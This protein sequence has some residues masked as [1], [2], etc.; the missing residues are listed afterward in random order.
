MKKREYLVLMALFVGTTLLP[1]NAYAAG[2]EAKKSTATVQVNQTPR[3]FE[4]YTV[5]NYSYFNLRDVAFI[6][7]NTEKEFS[8]E[9]QKENNAVVLKTGKPYAPVGT[10]MGTSS[11]QATQT[12]IPAT[13]KIKL[14]GE[15]IEMAV[16]LING[17]NYLKLRD[18][19]EALNFGVD[20]ND[21]TKTVEISSQKGY[22]QQV[23]ITPIKPWEYQ[24]MLGKGMDVDWSKTEQGKEAYDTK[25]VEDFKKAGFPMLGYV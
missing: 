12:A 1:M 4:A 15:E 11:N 20:W 16:Y 22:G 14:D 13:S 7:N 18:L 2:Y 21:D 24:K 25:A 9:W 8:V 10:E 5:N 17:N 23:G 6:L 3:S 19:G